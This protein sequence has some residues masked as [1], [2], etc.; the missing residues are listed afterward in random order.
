MSDL[1]ETKDVLAFLSEG[2]GSL[3]IARATRKFAAKHPSHFAVLAAF[4]SCTA[5]GAK[6]D[7]HIT[8][9]KGQL[10][11]LIA[12]LRIE[13]QVAADLLEAFVLG[14]Y[15]EMRRNADARYADAVLR[16]DEWLVEHGH[17]K[18]GADRREIA[19]DIVE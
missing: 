12:V 11:G 5:Y 17:Q 13:G 9:W 6:V 10:R 18:S 8:R 1:V 7:N 3:N 2:G 15:S 4:H 16:L 19:W 14:E